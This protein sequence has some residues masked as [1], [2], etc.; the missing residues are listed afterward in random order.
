MTNPPVKFAVIVSVHLNAK[1]TRYKP[2]ER[3]NIKSEIFKC[4][5]EKGLGRDEIRSF[6]MFMDGVMR[7]PRD[8]EIQYYEK[9]VR[10]LE[11]VHGVDYITSAE[12]FGIEQGMQQGMQQA[13]METAKKMLKE[14][15]KLEL[16]QRITGLSDD[17]LEALE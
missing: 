1:A 16:V 7:L 5:L 6:Y 15:F 14:G 13:N 12:R 9:V 2:Q 17:D 4:L 11:E 8:L 3:F 10:I